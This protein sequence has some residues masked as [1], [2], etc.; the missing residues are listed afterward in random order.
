MRSERRRE[1]EARKGENK[2]KMSE[3]SGERT[4]PWV[5]DRYE[6]SDTESVAASGE[7]DLVNRLDRLKNDPEVRH[8]LDKV[9]QEAYEEPYGETLDLDSPEMVES[10]DDVPMVDEPAP[11]MEDVV[12]HWEVSQKT[13]MP[14]KELHEKSKTV[15]RMGHPCVKCLACRKAL[16]SMTIGSFWQHVESKQ[17]YPQSALE[18]WKQEHRQKKAEKESSG[19]R[20]MEDEEALSE[21]KL[22]EIAKEEEAKKRKEQFK[23]HFERFR[24]NPKDEVKPEVKKIPKR[25]EEK[26][27]EK[28][29]EKE[30][31][32]SPSKAA[33]V[34][35]SRSPTRQPKD[36]RADSAQASNGK[37]REGHSWGQAIS[38]KGS[39]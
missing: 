22:Q 27:A 21:K 12:H 35:R 13:L 30:T 17:C 16:N 38:H 32:K 7:D 39:A 6:K 5:H 11:G 34:L 31:E 28:E 36:S 23:G 14:F 2:A 3:M 26:Q 10:D 15:S 9:L 24:T 18:F 25:P 8:K 33:I 1:D 29:P 19:K 20:P 4:P 37:V